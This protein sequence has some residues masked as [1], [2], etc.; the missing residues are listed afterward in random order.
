MTTRLIRYL[1]T[2]RDR[3]LVYRRQEGDLKLVC[4]VDGDWLTDYGNEGDNRN[5]PQ[6]MHLFCVEQRFRGDRSS[7]REWLDRQQS[8]NTKV[9][10]QL[11]VK[12]CM[13]EDR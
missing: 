10:G 6:G 9:Y 3:G 11:P 7:N 5:V 2:T 1:S 12:L 13:L 8:Q 4:Y